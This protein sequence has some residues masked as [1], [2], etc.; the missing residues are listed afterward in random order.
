MECSGAMELWAGGSS[1]RPPAEPA[2]RPSRRPA[3]FLLSAYII[4]PRRVGQCLPT[5]RPG[6][7]AGLRDE[8]RL[9]RVGLAGK[10]AVDEL[11]VRAIVS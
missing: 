7:A 6:I 1:G 4:S 3:S 10:A 11:F 9:R 2:E 8:A 5:K